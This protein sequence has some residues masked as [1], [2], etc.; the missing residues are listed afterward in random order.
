MFAGKRPRGLKVRPP[1]AKT[2]NV[3]T[4][5]AGSGSNNLTPLQR[6]QAEERERQRFAR[7]YELRVED[8]RK[9]A[10]REAERLA[11]AARSS[12]SSTSSSP[13]SGSRGRAARQRRI[14]VG[15]RPRVFLEM[16]LRQ[17]QTKGIAELGAVEAKGRMDF[18]LLADVVPR[19]VENFRQLCT[20]QNARGLHF[21]GC[22]FH[23]IVPGFMAQGGDLTNGNGTGGC[24]I[25]GP[26]FA[27][28]CF[29]EK[30]RGPGLLSMANS[31]P[32]TNNS[33]F[34]ITFQAQPH[35]D[36]RHVV[37]GRLVADPA[38]L[39]AQLEAAGGPDG[40][41]RR[42]VRISDSGESPAPM[43]LGW[44]PALQPWAGSHLL[45]QQ[46]QQQQQYTPQFQ[47]VQPLLQPLQFLPQPGVHFALQQPQMQKRSLAKHVSSSGSSSSSSSASSSKRRWRRSSSQRRGRAPCSSS[48]AALSRRSSSS[49]ANTTSS[50]SSSAKQQNSNDKSKER[51]H[52]QKQQTSRSHR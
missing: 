48:P 52:K 28:E 25:Y 43:P 45:L 6:L 30:H 51:K 22:P 4:N 49:S 18:E 21:R 42:S 5:G 16:E 3:G 31:G 38:R 46:Q 17:Q 12:S 11:R 19:T 37:F 2:D 1:L 36:G 9:H 23:R 35:L 14:S 29:S 8:E 15:P 32:N 13:S 41:P 34:F 44:G 10:E 50:R 7:D 27:D 24:S 26:T 47:L 20:G 39:L 40:R 33:Q